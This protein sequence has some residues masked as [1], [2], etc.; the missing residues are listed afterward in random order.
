MCFEMKNILKSNRYHT[1][2]H[3]LNDYKFENQH[4]K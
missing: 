1:S 2:K 3:A 4:S